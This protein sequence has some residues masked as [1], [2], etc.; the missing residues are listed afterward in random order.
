MTRHLLVVLA[1]VAGAAGGLRPTVEAQ[2]RPTV[3]VR[4][5]R[6]LDGKGG[7]LRNATVEIA[8]DKIVR[9][10]QR[11]GPVTYDLGAATLL[12]GMIDVHVHI[13]YHFGKDGRAQNRGE[14]P[15]EMALYAAENAWL[16][17]ASGFTTVQSAG[18][19]GDKDLRDAVNRGV[20][21]GPR[22]LSS[23]GSMNER[24]GEPE[25]L[26]AYVQKQKAEGA[27]FIKIFASKSIREGGAQTMTDA[28]LQ[29]A[30]AEAKAQGLRTLVHAQSDGAA[31]AA[32]KAGCSQVEHGSG[33]SDETL[34]FMA[35]QGTYFDPNIGLVLQ[36]YVENKARYLGIGNYNEEG[37]AFMEKAVPT[38]YAMFKRA[39]A[40]KVK[41][42][43][44]T[45]AV[46][47][48]HGQ[49]AREIITRVKDG[50]Q[51]PM[52]AILSA[53]SLA[54]E[55]IGLAQQIGALMP[56]LQADLVAV[57][58]DPLADIT[59]LRKVA[60]V[61]KGGQVY[62]HEPQPAMQEWPIYG[63]DDGGT[64]FSPLADIDRGNVAGLAPA[65]EWHPEE[66]PLEAF[67]TRPG[68]F[69]NTPLMI[70]N[71]LYVSTPYNRVVALDADTGKE[72]WRFDPKAYEDG[73]PPNGTGF[74]HRG[75]SAWR[76]RGK[77]RIFL[78]S[79]YRLFCLDADT[80]RPV[81]S[82]GTKGSIDLSRGLLWP[83]ER[84]HYTQTSPPVVYRDLVILGNGVGDRLVY[85]N[86]PP[87]DI[88]AFDARTGK[89]VWTFHT[90]P[91]RGEPGHDTW[92]EGATAT[93]GH[94]NAWA[95][96]TLD[97]ARGLLYVP[98]GTP[99]NDFYG[100]TR[101]GAGLYGESLV[102]LDAATGKRK[103][104]FQL[105]HHGIW[106]YDPP[107]PPNL[108]TIT[109]N[110]TRIDAVV[111][112]TKQGYAFVFDRVTGTPV[113]PIEER[114]VP[115]S[116]VKGEQA[117]PTQPV[118][119]LPPPFT[120]QGVTLDDAFDLT[121][122]LKAA[123]QA[124]LGTLRIGPLYTPPSTV[125][126]VMRPGTIGGSNWGGAAFDAQSGL[127]V[128]KTT[129]QPNVVRVAPADRSP[130]NPRA[131]E[132][133]AQFVG[134]LSVPST[135]VPPGTDASGRPF[136]PLPLLKPPYGH[137]VAIDLNRGAIAWRVPF[138]DNPQLREHPALAGV[139]LPERLGVPGAAG[140]LA[141]AGG[142]VFV[143]G[144]DLAF[145]ALDLA[146]GRELWTMTMPR[147]LT[148]TPMTYRSRAGRQF[149][150]VASSS[151]ADAALVAFALPT[152]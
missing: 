119:T 133:D 70:E 152:R 67:G 64:K 116:D 127:L 81:E 15:A 92:Q 47:G 110:G 77:L 66:V 97:A 17:L 25:A 4:A 11:T 40:A 112:L 61:M 91:Q 117:W 94:T 55:S 89:V 9:V 114:A 99:S 90:I 108:V 146:T 19:P 88:R 84:K 83:I 23:L 3:T 13:G 140:V 45:D 63:G 5:A 142:L 120:E 62:R 10:D 144:N 42:P 14:T 121:P 145:H 12:P 7:M 76:D 149:V 22:I 50:G 51:A 71:V 86:D 98:V 35:A 128:L 139:T 16:T 58:G 65:W 52:D 21:P 2:S 136:P 41:M 79:R 109:V 31:M 102:C 8:D 101:L 148:G 115:P 28:Q 123:A 122:A 75:L 39:L 26:R 6:V 80:G 72:K 138:G 151:G 36:N 27:D 73:Q 20:L 29:A 150:V 96:M 113:W 34:S 104:H 59:V 141:T 43:L 125:G 57:D 68:N 126:T 147:R 69:Q 24:T 87:G 60:F 53:T 129:N 135:F 54:A 56:G 137:V 82:F 143:G 48:A 49:N 30:C 18:A 33:I 106:D 130:A 85:K 32:A 44:G 78:N 134:D 46:A 37:F 132:V 1:L 111:Q 118:P 103:W 100:G 107:S 124:A 95:P 38:N 93:T 131:S 74:V 105:A